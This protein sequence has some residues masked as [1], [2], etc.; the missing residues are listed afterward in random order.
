MEFKKRLTLNGV[1]MD[2]NEQIY[3]RLQE[4]VESYPPTQENGEIQ[5]FWTEILESDIDQI[6][7]AIV[8]EMLTQVVDWSFYTHAENQALY[9]IHSMFLESCGYCEMFAIKSGMTFSESRTVSIAPNLDYQ[10]HDL[11]FACVFGFLF[12]SSWY[13]YMNQKINAIP[14]I[15]N[16]T[17]ELDELVCSFDELT[18]FVLAKGYCALHLALKM[19][20]K[21]V[22]FPKNLPFVIEEHDHGSPWVVY[23]NV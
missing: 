23:I 22:P 13:S 12:G 6:A 16:D 3:K 8:Q 18:E 21:R 11:E 15:Q 2:A 5:P 19:L 14:V 9:F 4:T 10:K 17:R 20:C 1:E 7:E